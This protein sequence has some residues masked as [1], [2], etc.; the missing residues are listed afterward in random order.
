ME[1][2]SEK[3][4]LSVKMYFHYDANYLFIHVHTDYV[5]QGDQG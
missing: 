2:S 1:G 4:V 5:G 3:N